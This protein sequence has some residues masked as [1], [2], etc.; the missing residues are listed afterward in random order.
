MGNTGILYGQ[1]FLSN[2]YPN[3]DG[4]GLK[5]PSPLTPE[6][7][8]KLNFISQVLGMGLID[9]P[10]VKVATFREDA[11]KAVR[12]SFGDSSGFLDSD[13]WGC[14]NSK[15]GFISTA[16]SDKVSLNDTDYYLTTVEYA[17]NFQP[18]AGNCVPEAEY[19]NFIAFYKS[20]TGLDLSTGI[21][22]DDPGFIHP[23]VVLDGRGRR[24]QL[25]TDTS[26]IPA[27]K[28]CSKTT[29][30]YWNIETENMVVS[31]I[32]LTEY[33]K[34][35]IRD[36]TYCDLPDEVINDSSNFTFTLTGLDPSMECFRPVDSYEYC[37][38][39][40]NWSFEQIDYTINH[41]LYFEHTI[42]D[43]RGI[44]NNPC[45]GNG[46]FH[47]EETPLGTLSIEVMKTWGR[48]KARFIT[49]GIGMV[50]SVLDVLVNAFYDPEAQAFVIAG[51]VIPTTW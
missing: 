46:Q 19:D 45:I 49:M 27:K 1:G 25:T 30:N 36:L 34:V 4:I 7:E 38:E 44:F 43:I 23:Q 5:R 17:A 48:E 15:E 18:V 28:F 42:D 6:S 12:Y 35:A 51:N 9:E 40:P 37:G 2:A 33:A 21:P 39:A 47:W 10:S 31:Y 32:G 8:A 41:K 11:F 20:V 24:I 14:D 29:Q 13:W 16:K 3:P 26:T 22:E 50:G